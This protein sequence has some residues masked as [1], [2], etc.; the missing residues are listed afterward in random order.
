M[1]H[2][3]FL[4]KIAADIDITENFG[5]SQQD[6]DIFLDRLVKKDVMLEKVRMLPYMEKKFIRSIER[7]WELII[8]RDMVDIKAKK[9]SEKTV[10]SEEEIQKRYQE[11]VAA[12]NVSISLEKIRQV[13]IADLREGKKAKLLNDWVKELIH[14]NEN[15]K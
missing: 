6:Q 15:F 8:I 9:I 14:E 13:I 4:K 2:E 1:T 7:Y 10:V 12:G 5:L 11:L 3:D